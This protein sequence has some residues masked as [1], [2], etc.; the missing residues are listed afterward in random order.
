MS[1]KHC[2]TNILMYIMSFLDNKS[3]SSIIS[4]CITMSDHGKKNGYLTKI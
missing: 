2:D 1:L 4:T 3:N